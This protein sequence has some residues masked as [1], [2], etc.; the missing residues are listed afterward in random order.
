MRFRPRQGLL[1][2]IAVLAAGS[3]VFQIALARICAALLGPHFALAVP[4]LALA[5]AGL[6][7][8]LCAAMPGLVRRPALLARLTYLAGLA[9]A[10]TLATLLVIV[11][12]KVPD[13]ITRDSLGPIA[14]VF[15]TA[16]LPFLFVG[17]GIGG[18][19]RHVPAL[20][21]RIVFSLF[22][23]AAVGAPLAFGALRVGP[24]AALLAGIAYALASLF[25]YLG[26]RSR[27]LPPTQPPQSP[28]PG[29]S[30]SPP[31][32]AEVER[33][34]GSIVATCLLASAVLFAGDLGSPWLKLPPLRFAPNEKAEL[35]EWSGLGLI[36]VDKPQGGISWI[37]TDGTAAVPIYDPK[38]S[39]PVAPDE[40]AYV[41]QHE[42]GPVAV[43]GA[44]GGREVRLALRYGQKEIHAIERDPVLVR[45][46]MLGR[47]QKTSADAYDNPMTTVAIEDG[48]GYVRRSGL[49][50]RN[51]EIPLPD[52][53][54]AEA[55]GS[56]AAQP[57][58]L[59]T[60]EA[61]T[62]LLDHLAPDG[63]LTVTRRDTDLD[64][65]LALTAEAL[66][67][68]GAASPAQHLFACGSDGAP[69]PD[70]RAKRP[71]TTAPPAEARS[72]TVLVKKTP[73]AAAEVAQLRTFCRRQR[74]VEAFAPDQPQGD[75]H[76][77]E[78]GYH[79]HPRTGDRP[80]FD[81]AVP[82]RLLAETILHPKLAESSKQA[83][84]VLAGLLAA[85]VVLAFFAVGLPLAAWPHW[86][87]NRVGPLLFFTGAGASL[88]FAW[89]ALGPRV[90]TMLGHPI[91]AFTTV[92]PALCA[93]VATGGL[94]A[95]RTYADDA[96]PRAGLRAELLVAVLAATAV[97][98]GPLV[99]VAIGL[100]FGVR[101]AAAVVLLVPVGAL[102]GAVLTLGIR[103]VAV[104]S[105][106]LV[107]WCWGMGGV[108][109]FV[110]VAAAMPLA[111][112]L[113]YSAVLLAAGASALLAAVCVPR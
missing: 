25:F 8:A 90:V 98:L 20:A 9:A 33:P 42:K 32:D 80:F 65:L 58:D 44:G 49:L 43:I 66:R 24:R 19:V 6:G 30:A 21:G 35:Q 50:F 96:A 107:P 57:S 41:L 4:T 95:N 15:L 76:R 16:T 52:S 38:T 83:L 13:G 75:A 17:I 2:G 31:D 93:A 48:R 113:G 69:A 81:Q 100:P 79:G 71:S 97:A 99:D 36:T 10:G 39:I 87:V 84:V 91:Y 85:A 47:Y 12:V 29:R 7:G 3:V 78:A 1:A 109:A 22:G 101:V 104:L 68:A 86:P 26:A 64:R 82:A 14:I 18:A 34:H 51:I 106:P 112:V 89:A 77:L 28:R 63:T 37:R 53:Q 11:H 70:T 54:T 111:L 110:A 56:L 60:V 73:F 72:T 94:L 105:P 102:A 61:F 103:L 55:T 67:R 59:F 74:F 45:A 46:V 62:D 40:M 23:G 108:G 88:A 5:G 92:I 27:L